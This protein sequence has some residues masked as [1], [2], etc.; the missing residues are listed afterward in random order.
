MGR[1]VVLVGLTR[2]AWTM[3]NICK[4]QSSNP[5]QKKKMGRADSKFYQTKRQIKLINLTFQLVLSSLLLS[6]EEA[7]YIAINT[8][9]IK[10]S[11][12]TWIHRCNKWLNTTSNK[13]FVKGPF[14]K[15]KKKTWFMAIKINL[16]MTRDYLKSMGLFFFFFLNIGLTI[17]IDLIVT[18]HY[19]KQKSTF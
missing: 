1:T 6:F 10:M 7:L 11:W 9:G 4:V 5:K 15:K 14:K 3:H 18:K 8:G 16:T 19:Y 2:L 13:D 17:I 12:S